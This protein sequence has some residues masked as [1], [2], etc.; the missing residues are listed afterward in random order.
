MLTQ[1]LSAPSA[2]RVLYLSVALS[3]LLLC[4]A[5]IP[6][7]PARGAGEIAEISALSKEEPTNASSHKARE[8]RDEN[9]KAAPA[10]S[11]TMRLF[12][13][14]QQDGPVAQPSPVGVMTI[15]TAGNKKPVRKAQAKQPQAKNGSH[16][17]GSPTPLIACSFNT[18][19]VLDDVRTVI[20]DGFGPPN[21][22]V[23]YTTTQTDPGTMGFC[24]TQAGPFVES[25]V[26]PVNFDSN[27]HGRSQDFFTQGLVLGDTV[28]YGTSLETGNTSTLQFTVIPQCNCPPIP[29]IP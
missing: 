5:I 21:S 3:L 12:V 19:L 29:V 25:I 2:P 6:L 23:N 26:V 1:F 28:T 9:Y 27:G 24:L 7:R 10:G 4:L 16:E 14:M 22:T 11:S 8:N 20:I 13:K 15:G 18:V 17:V